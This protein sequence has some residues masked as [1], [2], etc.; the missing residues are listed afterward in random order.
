MCRC[1]GVLTVHVR[2]L[3]YF[4]RRPQL[5]TMMV[6]PIL[7]TLVSTVLSLWL[8]VQFAMWPQLDLVTSHWHWPSWLAWT[9]VILLMLAEVAVVNMALFQSVFSFVQQ[10]MFLS[11]LEDR[12]VLPALREEKGKLPDLTCCRQISH[13]V[14][15][16]LV[17]LPLMLL[18]LP[19]H[20]APVAGQ[21]A[22]CLLNG[23]LYTWEA[24]E[25]FLVMYDDRHGW[26]QQG[27]FV[28]ERRIEYTYFG[29]AAMGLELIPFAGPWLFFAANTC[30]AA[31]M[32]ETF[33]E[34]THSFAGGKWHRDEQ[35]YSA[36]KG[37]YLF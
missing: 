10:K 12:G 34:E 29:A 26:W 5:W 4:L 2:G 19:L 27:Q 32:A 25:D 15:F 33:F 28:M 13:A 20:G 1:C 3:L 18:T 14:K 16:T 31:L 8:I 35:P 6:C 30:G 7:F 36:L 21:V 11:V 22:W 17:R 37:S 24:T 23:W 9:T